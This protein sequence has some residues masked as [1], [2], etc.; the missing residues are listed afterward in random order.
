MKSSE[1]VTQTGIF[2][3]HSGHVSLTDNLVACWDEARINRPTIG[4][5]EIALPSRND[6]PQRTE[7]FGTM[8]A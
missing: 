8:V 3:F 5:V 7:R 1:I 2:S 4:D 6:F